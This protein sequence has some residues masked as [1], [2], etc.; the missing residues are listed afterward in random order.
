MLTPLYSQLHVSALSGPSS[1]STDTFRERGQQNAC[2][3]VDIGL[4]SSVL[5]VTWQLSNLQK[6]NS[7]NKV[8]WTYF[9]AL[10]GFLHKIV[11]SVHGYKQDKGLVCV[12][13]YA[14]D[15]RPSA[16]CRE[17]WPQYRWRYPTLHGYD[18]TPSHLSQRT[19]IRLPEYSFILPQPVM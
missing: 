9:S 15:V 19:I 1:G 12:S 2:P 17:Q 6:C 4:N 10:V 14:R 13:E 3:D 16:F 18:S 8:V 11:T 5:Y 7:V